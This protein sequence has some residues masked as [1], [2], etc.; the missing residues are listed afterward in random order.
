MDIWRI[1]GGKRSGPYPDYEI[2]NRIRDGQMDEEEK[3]WHEGMAGW[4]KV[5][6]MELFKGEFV[7]KAEKP[8]LAKR[9]VPKLP[10]EYLERAESAA[11]N[12]Q[13]PGKNLG[14]RFWARWLDLSMYSALW[15]VVMYAAG[16]DIGLA[17]G[18][19]WMMLG[20]YLPWFA[21]ESFLIHR[22]GTTPGKWLM[23]LE[24]KNDDGTKLDLKAGTWRSIRVLV[25]GI[26]F[27]WGL[28]SA[29]CQTMSW[30]TARRIGRPIWDYLGGHKVEAGTL[31][32][33]RL[34][35]LVFLFSA[36]T[37]LQFAILGPHVE[38]SLVKQNPEFAKYYEPWHEW[39]FPVRR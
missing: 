36:V 33:M 32:M 28:L 24:V 30:F 6:D 34:V 7:P 3:L 35:G 17:M 4:T 15:W 29:L 2:R 19:L 22:F 25:T 31:H 27:G 18:S 13:D 14:R 20:K 12:K 9:G 10:R 11:R 16:R 8:A 5:G 21:L 23:S 1:V 26:G 37:L 38:E 39:Y